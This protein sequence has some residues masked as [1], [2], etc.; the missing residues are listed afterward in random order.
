MVVIMASGCHGLQGS[1]SVPTT[2]IVV[3][4]GQLH[5]AVQC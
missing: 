2:I 3:T 4:W 5:G 1:P